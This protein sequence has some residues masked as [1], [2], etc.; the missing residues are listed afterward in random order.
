MFDQHQKGLVMSSQVKLDGLVDFKDIFLCLLPPVFRC[1]V[2]SA[3]TNLEIKRL[4]QPDSMIVA[5]AADKI[6]EV[7]SIHGKHG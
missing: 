3:L 6:Y 7:D 5:N 4:E 1:G 2:S